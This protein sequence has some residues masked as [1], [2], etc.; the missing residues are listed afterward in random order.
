MVGDS[1]LRVLVAGCAYGGIAT[2]VNLLDLSLGK[3]PRGAPNN[4]P[5]QAAL[6]GIPL[7]IHIVDER[8]G[9]LHLIGCPLAF[10]SKEHAPKFWR[11][12]EDIPALQHPSISWTRG[13]ITKIDPDRM[14]AQLTDAKTGDRVEYHYDYFIGAT[15]LK[16]GFPVV[17]EQLTKSSYLEETGDHVEAVAAAK[18]GIVV[19]GGGAVGV[20]MAAELKVM[21][22]SAK[23]TLIQSREALL[24]AEPLPDEFKQAS[25]DALREVG[26]EVILGKGR[27]VETTTTQ[28][29]DGTSVQKLTLKDGSHVTANHVI[30][31]VSQQVP[32]TSYFPPRSLDEEG[33]VKINNKFRFLEGHKNDG[34]H[35]AIGDIVKWSGIKRCGAAMHMGFLASE[36]VHKQMLYERDNVEPDFHEFP[37]VPPMIALAI[38]KKAATYGPGM[39]V[40]CSEQQMESFFGEDLGFTGCW[41]H[42]KLSEAPS[43]AG[44]NLYSVLP[45]TAPYRDMK[46]STAVTA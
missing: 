7:D 19:I 46:A 17:P 11:K 4:V 36:N 24:S 15:G 42:L 20:E 12:F 33:F 9:Y 35:Y 32:C 25:L 26:V 1:P 39:G 6:K 43:S 13:S 37:E 45:Q 18:D 31:A 28:R 34:R 41:N 16:R 23:V 5:H 2:V 29:D 38:G 14:V 44:I 30:N 21:Q 3:S 8:D 22:P 27:V 10:A 40:E